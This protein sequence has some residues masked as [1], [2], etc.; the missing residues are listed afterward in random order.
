MDA[1]NY[2]SDVGQR[3]PLYR[4]CKDVRVF[5]YPWSEESTT[6]TRPR[7]AVLDMQCLMNSSPRCGPGRL[8]KVRKRGKL[9]SVNVRLKTW[10]YSCN[11]YFLP[12]IEINA[13][14]WITKNS[15]PTA[16]CPGQLKWKL[17]PRFSYLFYSSS[18]FISISLQ[19][20]GTKVVTTGHRETQSHT[21]NVIV[22]S[23]RPQLPFNWK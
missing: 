11:D 16:N 12:W 8:A 6:T 13:T 19:A 5:A 10:N 14:P 17:Y 23:L 7:A 9:T 4:S 20:S 21:M 22:I 2:E 3:D 15:G 18:L 1:H